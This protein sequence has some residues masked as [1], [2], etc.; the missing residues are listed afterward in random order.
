M[1]RPEA[2]ANAEVAFAICHGNNHNWNVDDPSAKVVY[3]HERANGSKGKVALVRWETVCRRCKTE[4]HLILTEPGRV[5][6][7]VFHYRWPEGYLASDHPEDEV[8][9]RADWRDSFRTSL[10]LAP[11]R[12]N[13]GGAR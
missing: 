5:Q 2:P 11:P 10:P 4:R 6:V 8:R 7:G 1:S 12:P 13:G 9:S 3:V